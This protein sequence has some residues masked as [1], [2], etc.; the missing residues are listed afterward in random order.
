MLAAGENPGFSKSLWQGS[1]TPGISHNN[2]WNYP[3]LSGLNDSEKKPGSIYFGATETIVQTCS[4]VHFQASRSKTSV[5]SNFKSLRGSSG[6]GIECKLGCR[7][8]ERCFTSFYY[9]LKWSEMEVCW[10]KL[11]CQRTHC[12]SWYFLIWNHPAWRVSEVDKPLLSGTEELRHHVAF[13]LGLMM[14]MIYE[15]SRLVWSEPKGQGSVVALNSRI[16]RCLFVTWG[17]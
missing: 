3:S 13:L 12:F 1:K 11:R 17:A 2:R 9:V 8:W 4:N 16:C 14:F 6:E 15:F 7:W 10:P 5:A